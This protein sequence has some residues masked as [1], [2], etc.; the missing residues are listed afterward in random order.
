MQVFTTSQL[1]YG[2]RY[3]DT[4]RGESLP[5]WTGNFGY[6]YNYV[7][8]DK[9]IVS[10]DT[11][12]EFDN[13]VANSYLVGRV[14]DSDEPD[15]EPALNWLGGGSAKWLLEFERNGITPSF[16]MCIIG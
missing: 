3:N 2:L 13:P 4:Y 8:V 5:E 7:E 16:L 10:G 12:F 1:P 11:S 14:L 6:S 15:R 9:C